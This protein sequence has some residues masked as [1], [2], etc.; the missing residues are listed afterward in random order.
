MYVP[1][2]KKVHSCNRC[3]LTEYTYITVL[4]GKYTVY[5]GCFFFNGIHVYTLFYGLSFIVQ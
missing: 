1:Y 4:Y 5:I 3:T 2:T